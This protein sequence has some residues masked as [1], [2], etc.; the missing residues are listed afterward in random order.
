MSVPASVPADVP[1][2][3]LDA[4]PEDAVLL[5]VRELDEWKAGHVP[6]AVHVPL[7]ELPA[8]LSEVPAGEP[9]VVTCRGGGRSARAVQFLRESGRKAVNL[10]GGMQA[11]AAA[12][13]VMEG[14]NGVKPS[15]I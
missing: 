9:L 12:D 7:G 15:V 6:G 13:R 2:V 8:R 14:D 4:V 10:Q 1:A 11:W 5:D 3:S